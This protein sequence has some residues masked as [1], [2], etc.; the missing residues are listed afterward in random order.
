MEAS[1][2]GEEDPEE[3][4]Q[5]GEEEHLDGNGSEILGARGKGD[6]L[7]RKGREWRRHSTY[8]AVFLPCHSLK[9]Q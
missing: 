2:W 1:R 8:P 3:G 6:L 5:S 9:G 4:R 7:K